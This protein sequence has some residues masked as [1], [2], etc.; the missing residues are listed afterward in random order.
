MADS[1][2][3]YDIPAGQ[4][5]IVA[6]YLDGLYAWPAA[7]WNYHSSS[8]HFTITVGSGTLDADC[9]DVENGDYTPEEGA[10]WA[11]R[12]IYQDGFAWLY[13]SLSLFDQV[14]AAVHAQGINDAQW[15]AWIALW[16]NV[17]QLLPSNSLKQ[18][19]NPALT[20]RH[21]DLSVAADYLPGI[22][23]L[24]QQPA[25]S[26]AAGSLE[27]WANLVHVIDSDLPLVDSEFGVLASGL[28]GLG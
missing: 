17:P 23:P 3:P 11:Q 12:K 28:Q 6:G 25:Q 9:A 16:D 27:G 15:F 10:A 21:Y 22:D 20:G 24:P 2:N 26:M 8:L 1:T 4:F 5:P 18:Y 13:F 7:G 19:A 14:A